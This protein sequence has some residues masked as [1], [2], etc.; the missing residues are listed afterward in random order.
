LQLATNYL[1]LG[2]ATNAPARYYS[3]GRFHGGTRAS[4][5]LNWQQARR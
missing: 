1:D 5:H 3:F 4:G 2:A